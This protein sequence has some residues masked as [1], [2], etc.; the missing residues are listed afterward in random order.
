MP[1]YKGLRH[2]A[3]NSLTLRRQ[4]KWHWMF[5]PKIS[6]TKKPC[7]D[8]FL[9]LRREL[10]IRRVVKYFLKNFDVFDISSQS[11]LKL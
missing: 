11:K 5:A 7:L 4:C 1:S 3:L 6:K 2:V 8:T 10:K 9:T